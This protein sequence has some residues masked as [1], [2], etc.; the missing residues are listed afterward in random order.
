MCGIA[1]AFDLTGRREFPEE[2]LLLMTG[3]LAHRGPNDEYIYQEPGLALGVRRLSV[4][5]VAH[6][7]QPLSNETGD[8]WVAY[9]GELYDFPELRKRL[10]DRGHTLRTHCDTE[11]WPHLYEDHG[12]AAFEHARGQFAVALWDRTKRKLL[13]GRDRPGIAPLFYT[14]VD[15]W[16]LWASEIK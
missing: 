11:A 2:R 8:V 7:R 6:G 14:Q 5:D 15:G 12:D 13:I 9:E 16:L 1:G 10:I 3:A 4:I